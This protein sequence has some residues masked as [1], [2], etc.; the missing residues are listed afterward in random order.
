MRLVSK[1]L[2]TL[3]EKA[4][5]YWPKTPYRSCSV[6][7]W[8]SIIYPSARNKPRKTSVAWSQLYVGAEKVKLTKYR[9]A[10]PW[11]LTIEKDRTW[12]GQYWSEGSRFHLDPRSKRAPAWQVDGCELSW[13]TLQVGCVGF[14]WSH[15]KMASLWG[16]G[17]NSFAWQS[18]FIMTSCCTPQIATTICYL[19]QIWKRTTRNNKCKESP[20]LQ[21]FD[22]LVVKT[23]A[24]REI[25]GG[26]GEW[27]RGCLDSSWGTKCGVRSN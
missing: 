4:G 2:L 17:T 11:A 5:T 21:T 23:Q 8:G 19:K 7:L 25:L 3:L 20:H 16:D 26:G 13:S 10:W 27:G 1:F 14:K 24:N 22:I 18:S 15:L 6:G 12:S 9:V